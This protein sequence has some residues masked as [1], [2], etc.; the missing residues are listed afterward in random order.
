[1]VSPKLWAAHNGTQV[2]PWVL[3]HRLAHGVSVSDLAGSQVP[4]QFR[5]MCGA[6]AEAVANVAAAAPST[7]EQ[8]VLVSAVIANMHKAW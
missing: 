8:Q 6:V 3:H 4:E 2:Q 1:M 5:T 7:S